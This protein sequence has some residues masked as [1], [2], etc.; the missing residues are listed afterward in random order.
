MGETANLQH[1]DELLSF[2]PWREV[3]EKR[4]HKFILCYLKNNKDLSATADAFFFRTSDMS[5]IFY[6]IEKKLSQYAPEEKEVWVEVIAPPED[7]SG[8]FEDIDEEPRFRLQRIMGEIAIIENRD[9]IFSEQMYVMIEHLLETKN[10]H[11]T[12]VL[13]NRTV[14]Y[15]LDRVFGRK[16]P[17]KPTE[18]GVLFQVQRYPHGAVQYKKIWVSKKSIE[19]RKQTRDEELEVTCV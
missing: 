2:V 16:K 11:D 9:Q 13:L 12:A 6:R 10:V 18:K 17:R 4:Y 8:Y 1:V 3:L 5:S 19:S 7:M 15:L 14:S